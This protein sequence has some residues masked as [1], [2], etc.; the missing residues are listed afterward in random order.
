VTA[1]RPLRLRRNAGVRVQRLHRNADVTA[2][3]NG[4]MVWS[5]HAAALRNR[6]QISPADVGDAP[7]SHRAPRI[8]SRS[9]SKA[10]LVICQLIDWA[11]TFSLPE[12]GIVL[13]GFP[14]AVQ[15]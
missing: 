3:P 9:G 6:L 10:G 7:V 12:L 1:S 2:R 4:P 11:S 13:A 15:P 14:I 8:S 5:R